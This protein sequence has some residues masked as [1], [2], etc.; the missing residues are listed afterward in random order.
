VGRFGLRLLR[1]TASSAALVELL[2]QEWI[3]AAIMTVA[4]ILSIQAER[5][6]KADQ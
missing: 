3:A 2:R 1:I 5:S 4:W 6:I